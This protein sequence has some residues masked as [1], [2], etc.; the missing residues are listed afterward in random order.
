MGFRCDTTDQWLETEMRSAAA[1]RRLR[2]DSFARGT[3]D[4]SAEA[5]IDIGGLLRRDWK[6]R[7]FKAAANRVF[8]QPTRAR[9]SPRGSEGIIA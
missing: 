3:F 2:K 1:S 5:A 6:S 7:P 9:Y 4:A 8:P